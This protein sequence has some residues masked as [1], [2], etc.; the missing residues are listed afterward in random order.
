MIAPNSGIA[1]FLAPGRSKLTVPAR[2]Q[3]NQ[4]NLV[5]V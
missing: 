4:H 1:S 2:H 3:C 5:G